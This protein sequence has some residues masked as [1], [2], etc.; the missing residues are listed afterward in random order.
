MLFIYLM[1]GYIKIMVYFREYLLTKRNTSI[2]SLNLT[3][4]PHIYMRTIKSSSGNEKETNISLSSLNL[5][6]HFYNET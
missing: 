2:H 3:L 1:I 4:K 5:P 6:P